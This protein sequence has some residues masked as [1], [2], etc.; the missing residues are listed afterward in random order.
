MTNQTILQCP[1]CNKIAK[2]S[3]SLFTHFKLHDKS[4]NKNQNLFDLLYPSAEKIC[5]CCGIPTEFISFD[6]GYKNTC[7][8][9]CATKLQW[10]DAH[11]R[12]A[13]LSLYFSTNNPGTGRPLGQKNKQPYPSV[14]RVYVGDE[15]IRRRNHRIQMN[16]ARQP[17]ENWRIYVKGRETKLRALHNDTQSTEFTMQPAQYKKL[18]DN[19]TEL[20]DL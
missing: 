1:V 6:K 12:K 20:F 9:S 15:L 19:L 18:N 16:L 10:R 2:N 8:S 4:M 13:T 7:Q 17:E 11:E 3:R 14:T 5:K